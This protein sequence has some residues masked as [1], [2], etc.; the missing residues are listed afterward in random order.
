MPPGLGSRIHVDPVPYTPVGSKVECTAE[1]AD[2]GIPAVSGRRFQRRSISLRIA[3]VS[4]LE[5]DR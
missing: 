3:I 5:C 2:V 1:V 4:Y